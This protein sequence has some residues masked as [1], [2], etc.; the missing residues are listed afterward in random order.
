MTDEEKIQTTI[1]ALKNELRALKEIQG[2]IKSVS[3]YFYTYYSQN[4][5]QN[6]IIR[7]TFTSGDTPIIC[8]NN[9]GFSTPFKIQN[10]TQ[11]YFFRLLYAGA[12]TFFSTRPIIKV[13]NIT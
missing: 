9:A 4:T 3:G 12:T 13:E 8:Y 7:V 1:I 11:E 6:Q 10:N 5:T 2:V